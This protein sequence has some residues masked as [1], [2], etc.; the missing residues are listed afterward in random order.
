MKWAWKMWE[1]TSWHNGVLGVNLGKKRGVRIFVPVSSECAK[2]SRI[3]RREGREYLQARAAHVALGFYVCMVCVK[4][5]DHCHGP[6][7]VRLRLPTG[8][9]ANLAWLRTT[10]HANQQL[11][12]THSYPA[13]S[14]H[15]RRIYLLVSIF[16]CK[17]SL[18]SP[19]FP[20]FYF[21]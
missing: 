16:S 3:K 9:S 6:A 2:A 1:K 12:N 15:Y 18:Y 4:D 8:W 17:H 10:Y 5:L 7:C 19:S 13:L 14:S 21:T 20:F 11:T